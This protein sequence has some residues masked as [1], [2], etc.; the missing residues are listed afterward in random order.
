M[1]GPYSVLG[2]EREPFGIG[3]PVGELYRTEQ[4]TEMLSRLC[5]V[6][7][8][9]KFA[10]LTADPGCGK[11][12]LLRALRDRLEGQGYV[13]I[14]ISDSSLS[15]R[16]LYNKMLEQLGTDRTFYYRGDGKK[17][18]HERLAVLHAVK[19]QRI[20]CCV[21]EAHLLCPDTIQEIR[22]LLN[23]EMDSWSPLALILSGQ[24]ELRTCLRK[25]CWTA[26]RQRVGM[27]CSLSPLAREQT[28]DYVRAHLRYAG[29]PDPE[30]F[31]KEAL[32]I[33]QNYSQGVPR[34]INNICQHSLLRAASRRQDK[35]DGATVT[36]V[37]TTEMFSPG[38]LGP[39]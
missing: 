20:V 18:V 4:F 27:V 17:A 28:E 9:Q 32:D 23:C 34:E 26:V 12:T 5:F 25:D 24:T 11:S 3:V 36:E 21:D 13:F 14:Y 30:I 19:R 22:F 39:A 35:V 31:S 6:A 2:L 37:A 38:D 33:V 15:P 7:E 1:S 29:A 16:W 10:V 8:R